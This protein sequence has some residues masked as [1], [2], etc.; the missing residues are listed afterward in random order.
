MTVKQLQ[1]LAIGTSSL[2]LLVGISYW[3]IIRQFMSLYDD[4]KLN[5]LQRIYE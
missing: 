4:G 2:K 5:N 1:F 3:T